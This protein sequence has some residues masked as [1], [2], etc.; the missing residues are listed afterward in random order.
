[1]KFIIST[2][3]FNFLI[4]K[5]LNVVSQKIT[6]PILSN[7]LIEAQND[8]LIVTATDLVVG[9]RC[10]TDAKILEEG[11]TTLP[12]KK[13][14]QLLRELTALHLEIQTHE[15]EVTHIRADSS[16]FKLKGMDRGEFPSLP[17]IHE[18]VQFK[19]PERKLKDMLFRTA[20]AVSHEDTRYA[21][22]GVLMEIKEGKVAFIGTDGKRLARSYLSIDLDPNFSGNYI[23]PLKAVEEIHRN[24]GDEGD[25]ILYL[26]PD[27]VA[28]E[29]S[30]TTIIS[31]LL[32]G[33]YPDVNRIIPQ[34]MDIVVKLHREELITLLRQISLF[35][36]ENNSVRLTFEDG[37]LHIAA[38]TSEIGEGKVSMPANYH[39]SKLDIAFNPRSLLDIL[40][41]SKGE[42][43]P[44]TVTMGLTDSYNPGIITDIGEN[45]LTPPAHTPLFMLMPM[46]LNEE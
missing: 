9:M 40:L 43:E 41:H 17:S 34:N 28:V 45:P 3:E 16:H 7:I 38:N 39:G 18:A 2:Q 24:L 32:T 29:S 4:S 5:C 42:S 36:A 14:A 10:F 44:E 13:L 1:M 22:T 15:N 30:N 11:S 35:A 8:E 23:I 31:K 37:E 6:A 21:L 25:A 46:R 27:K 12:A 26:M 33:E 19:I 20:F